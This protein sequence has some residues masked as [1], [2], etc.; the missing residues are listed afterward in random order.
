MN[1][2]HND[3]LACP[4]TDHGVEVV[5]EE[6]EEASTIGNEDTEVLLAYSFSWNSTNLY[7]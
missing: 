7:R 4:T 6:E 3:N 5:V 2:V 1:T